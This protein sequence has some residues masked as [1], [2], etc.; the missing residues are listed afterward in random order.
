MTKRRFQALRKF[1]GYVKKHPRRIYAA[2]IIVAFILAVSRRPDVVFHPQFWAEDGE[3]WYANAYNHGIVSTLFQT[4]AGYFALIHRLVADLSLAL[5]LRLAPLFFNS[6][7]IAIF[8]L[9]VM[10]INSS[11][12]R[13]VIPN[14]YAAM[15]TSLIYIGMLNISEIYG[16]LANIQWPLA[17]SAFLVLFLQASPRRIWQVCDVL[18]LLA[19]GVSGPAVIFLIPIAL[20]LWWK[21]K[22]FQSKLNLVVLVGTTLLQTLGLLVF[23]H[24]ERIGQQ[25]YNHF[26]DLLKI[27]SGQ[28]FVGSVAGEKYI[29]NFY[30]NNFAMTLILVVGLALIAYAVIK[31]PVWLKALNFFAVCMFFAALVSLHPTKGLNPWDSLTYPTSGQRYWFVPISA[32]LGTLLWLALASRRKLI[33]GVSALILLFLVVFGWPH[34]WRIPPLFNFHFHAYADQFNA[35]PPG[36]KVSIPV[37]PLNTPQWNMVLIKK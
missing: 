9:P 6:V 22:S 31:G 24:Y 27:I 14:V 26:I 12:F 20:Y 32:W 25:H 13:K 15:L 29:N 3:I 18:I 19:A 7:G 28:I 35:A 34:A 16:N 8:L 17:L 30:N 10:I 21:S 33:M 4:Y 5:P 37:N 36:T 1:D 2:I 11:R 23:S